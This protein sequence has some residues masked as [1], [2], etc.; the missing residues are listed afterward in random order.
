MSA[1]TAAP[2]APAPSA[3][4]A[5][6]AAYVPT[7]LPT[8]YDTRVDASDLGVTAAIYGVLG[9]V[10][11]ALYCVG[12]R[13][14]PR[15]YSPRR[16]FVSA[17]EVALELPKGWVSWV[18]PLLHPHKADRQILAHVGVDAYVSV[19]MM[20]LGFKLFTVLSLPGMVVLVPLYYTTG[21]QA[22][23]NTT[24]SLFANLD[25]MSMAY[26][27]SSP[28]AAGLAYVPA[29]MVWFYSFVGIYLI[30]REYEH[31]VPI[32]REYY[33]YRHRASYS[34]LVE[35]IP[36]DIGS[37]KALYRYFETVFPRSVLRVDLVPMSETAKKLSAVVDERKD[38]VARLERAMLD[39]S[40]GESLTGAQ[41]GDRSS[42]APETAVAAAWPA[43]E[44]GSPLAPEGDALRAQAR[45]GQGAAPAAPAPAA[46][47]AA[48]GAEVGG[49]AAP[50]AP[51][52]R[53]I[54]FERGSAWMALRGF[55]NGH[56][57]RL[58]GLG[59][60]VES[61]PYYSAELQRLNAEVDRLQA[62]LRLESFATRDAAYPFVAKRDAASSAG[63]G[64]QQQRGPSS[65]RSASADSV[66][67][68]GPGDNEDDDGVDSEWRF[69][70]D[71]AEEAEWLLSEHS[72][73]W[74]ERENGGEAAFITLVSKAASTALGRGMESEKGRFIV[75]PA[76]EPA[77]V[78]WG[79]LAIHPLATLWARVG[80][81]LLV[82]IWTGWVDGCWRD[83]MRGAHRGKARGCA[84]AG[85]L[86]KPNLLACACPRPLAPRPS[87]ST[88][89]LCCL[90][91]I[92]LLGLFGMLTATIA[93]YTSVASMRIA[94]PELD[95]W[96][97]ENP[98]M[99][100]VVGQIMPLLLV[101]AF[102]LVP[103]V[104][105][106]ILELRFELSLSGKDDVFFKSYYAFLVT[107]I[108]LFYQVSGTW[109]LIAKATW[110]N[111]TELLFIV[112][113]AISSNSSFFMQYLLIRAFWVLPTN[114]LRLG[115][116]AVAFLVRPLFCGRARTPRE[117]R[118]DKCG[119]R[120]ISNGGD[121]WHG[122]VNSQIMLALTIGVAYAA[123]APVVLLVA[124][125][126]FAVAL[127]V[128]R[129][130]YLYVHVKLFER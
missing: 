16:F 20:L 38:V 95:A 55:C 59:R 4:P 97:T 48:A 8:S 82:S 57:F 100:V 35:R 116:I 17:A 34:I 50:A 49:Q 93:I 40:L 75:S 77:D 62:Q 42:A 12:R 107:Q 26:M 23:A 69:A 25:K 44:L 73:S 124:W 102:A 13:C 66:T 121:A 112:A 81:S 90:Q 24:G 7:P 123:L 33:L 89:R 108:F 2:S 83:C 52:A 22:G 41:F 47:G 88:N 1:P 72:F 10:V 70:M 115:D 130:Q 32:Q 94:W 118:D 29:F 114:M 119:C 127:V 3:T 71:K 86:R 74:N 54:V 101:I 39:D 9:L 37:R 15:V 87:I 68:A 6:S 125:A 60:Y 76:P 122:L 28:T 79:R 14:V 85:R 11:L 106:L 99:V 105:N 56:L 78:N 63:G 31:L 51:R 36:K 53:A 46:A 45:A 84:G 92:A 30:H 96:L 109:F 129:N 111:P 27:L 103:P 126:Y 104:L 91:L 5:P 19:R 110:K 21:G 117:V 65:P 58:C 80:V 120:T 18:V 61:V 128:Y 67:S 64:Q 43:D 113:S 98:A